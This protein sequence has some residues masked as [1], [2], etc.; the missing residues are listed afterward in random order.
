MVCCAPFTLYVSPAIISISRIKNVKFCWGS[1]STII[2]ELGN[3]NNFKFLTKI[4]FIRVQLFL[5]VKKAILGVT[6]RAVSDFYMAKLPICTMFLQ[7]FIAS[8][9]SSF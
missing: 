7:A 9:L 5:L 1:F 6:L 4:V 3:M 2:P 8:D